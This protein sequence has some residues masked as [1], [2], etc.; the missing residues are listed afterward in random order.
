[1]LRS[2][3][4]EN[5]HIIRCNNVFKLNLERFLLAQRC[6]T[7]MTL[8]LRVNPKN[9]SAVFPLFASDKLKKVNFRL[10][11]IQLLCPYQL[12]DNEAFKNF[13]QNHVSSLTS[14]TIFRVNS[15]RILNN[16]SGMKN[17]KNVTI[18]I[19]SV[20]VDQNDILEVQESVKSLKMFSYSPNFGEKF[21]NL[22]NLELHNVCSDIQIEKL[23]HL[24]NFRITKC[25]SMA[26]K[27]PSSVKTLEFINHAFKSQPEFLQPTQ[28]EI[29]TLRNCSQISWLVDF[30]M[31]DEFPFKFLE[32]TDV[33][34]PSDCIQVIAENKRRIKMKNIKFL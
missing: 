18:I 10:N 17:L 28:I 16:F 11:S 33:E 2:S 9:P 20:G 8:D 22:T 30:L 5:I 34:L 12:V 27:F 21:P 31:A 4:V 32:L 26:M 15:I 6:L 13:C 3:T 25:T 1:M 23:K 24:T 29:L 19:D 14:L 7:S